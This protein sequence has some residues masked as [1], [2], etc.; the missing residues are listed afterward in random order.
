MTSSINK[1]IQEQIKEKKMLQKAKE[2]NAEAMLKSIEVMEPEAE[3][4]VEEAP[5]PKAVKAPTN[6]KTVAKKTTT[7]KKTNATKKGKK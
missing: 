2:K 7:V 3:V 1:K 5:K 4:V 6:K